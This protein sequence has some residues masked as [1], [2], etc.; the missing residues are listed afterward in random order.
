MRTHDGL[1]LHVATHGPEHAPLT[2]VLAH[3]WTADMEDWHYQ[4]RSLMAR[5][6][7]G[8]RIVTWDHRGHGRSTASP[9]LDCTI[10]TLAR[11]M[12]GVVDTHA[13]RGPL[14]LAGHSIGGMTMM[15]LADLRPDLVTR[16]AG[17]LFVATS[18]EGLDSVT[19]GLR[20]LGPRLKAQLPRMLELRARLLTRRQRRRA[21]ALERWVVARFLFGEPMRHRDAG[22]VVDQLVSCPPE[23]MRGFYE[24]CLRHARTAALAAFHDVPTVVMVGDRD[25]L[26]PV[27]HARRISA[28]V[29][30]SRLVVAPGAGHM[31]TLERHELVTEEL[32]ALVARAHP[33]RALAAPS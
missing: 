5:F 16:A 2:V 14:V 12:A 27:E 13:P 8:I 1:D 22:L 33:D 28:A 9:L 18:S 32:A 7:H 26:T 3:C 17:V 6:G 10:D 21:P 31:L 19:L 23:T 11:D 4:V 25:V 24:D 15:A 30:G 20:D 29:R